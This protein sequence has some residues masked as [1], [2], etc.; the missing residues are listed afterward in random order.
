MNLETNKEAL[1]EAIK[2]ERAYQDA[3]WGPLSER[4][5]KS[6]AGWYLIAREELLEAQDAF[7]SRSGNEQALAELLQFI[8]TGHAC[9]EQLEI[10][11]TD[12]LMPHCE[13]EHDFEWWLVAI[14]FR[15]DQTKRSL[16]T[17]EHDDAEEFFLDAICVAM[18]CLLQHGVVTRETL[19]ER[20]P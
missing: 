11:P 6:L 17:L 9:M 7:N 1:L 8:A 3:K 14:E 15:L 4:K 19:K 2:Q 5:F 18:A 20:Q 10:V 12:Y 16:F 13:H